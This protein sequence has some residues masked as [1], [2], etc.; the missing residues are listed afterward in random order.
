M[1]QIE[2]LLVVFA[3]SAAGQD[4]QKENGIRAF[5]EIASV[6]TSP[7]CINCHI[8][9]NSPLQ[10]D[11]AQIHNMEVMR[12]TDGKGGSPTM[13]CSNCHQEANVAAP[14]APPGAE[15]WRL[16]SA[17]TPMAWQGLTVSQVCQAL[18]DPATNGKR[19]LQDLIE[20]VTTDK[21]VNWG[22][23]PG[24]GRTPPPLSHERFVERV[25]E[26]V[27]AGAPCPE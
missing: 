5:R 22:W 8:P 12:G 1:K 27:A 23:N 15:G 10:G 14:H 19:S 21:I 18:K 3:F 2:V 6:L 13:H 20:H 26:W 11:H 25:S 7:R 17:A 9:G 16:P 4:T 24:P